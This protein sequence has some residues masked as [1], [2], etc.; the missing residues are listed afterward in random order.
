[1]FLYLAEFCRKQHGETEL[2]VAIFAET[3]LNAYAYFQHFA[4]KYKMFIAVKKSHYEKI[5]TI[6][7]KHSSA[8]PRKFSGL[9]CP[10]LDKREM[11]L[12]QV[13]MYNSIENIC[14]CIEID[15]MYDYIKIY[16]CLELL[17]E[18]VD[19]K[20]DCIGKK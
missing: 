13:N 7:G 15:A 11:I 6:G 4:S 17:A 3:A 5:R 2:I 12:V 10:L 9:Y 8:S 1:M 16:K 14:F 18:C 20:L 19:M